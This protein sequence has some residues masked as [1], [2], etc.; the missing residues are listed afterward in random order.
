MQFRLI[1][2]FKGR[3]VAQAVSRRPLAAEVRVWSRL[4]ACE[5]FGGQSGAETGV[6]PS[7]FSVIPSIFHIHLHLHVALR[8]GKAFEAWGTSN[9]ALLCVLFILSDSSRS[10]CYVQMFIKFRRSG[11][12]QNKEYNFQ[13]TANI[14]S[15]DSNALSEIGE[16]WVE[17]Y[18]HVFRI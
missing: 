9:R 10:E 5:I 12:T 4:N 1:F 14:L 17:K 13:N 2:I 3:A 11:I 7:T 16:L 18:C 15:Q 6:S 8:R